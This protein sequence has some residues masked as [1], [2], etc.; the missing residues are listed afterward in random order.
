MNQIKTEV[1]NVGDDDFNS[2][3]VHTSKPVLIDFWA[4]WCQPC[5]MLA[6]TVE[7]LAEEYADRLLVGKMNVDEN[8]I[9]P[10]RYGI[11]G[12]PALFLFVEGKIVEKIV[13]V[14]PKEEI[15]NIINKHI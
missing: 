11:R 15:K 10:H 13:G 8:P 7:A 9:T 3:V 1:V 5:H 12:I 4:D 6:P 2:L 14:K